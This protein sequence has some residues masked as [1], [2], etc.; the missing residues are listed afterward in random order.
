MSVRDEQEIAVAHELDDPAVVLTLAVV[1]AALGCVVLLDDDLKVV[2]ASSA[3][4]RAFDIDARGV[5]GRRYDELAEGAWGDP[6]LRRLLDLSL[7]DSA[8]P[9]NVTFDLQRRGRITRRL[10]ASA[11]RLICAEPDRVR[12]LLSVAD[13]TEARTSEPLH[14]L[15]EMD[16]L[17]LREA[18]HR[19]SNGLHIVAGLLWQSARL[20]E[21][22]SARGHLQAAYGRVTA[23]A[24]LERQLSAA[25]DEFVELRAYLTELCEHLAESAIDDSAR[26]SLRFFVDAVVV[27]VTTAASLGMIVTEL[28]VNALKHA[29]PG[30]RRGNVTIT[31]DAQGPDWTLTVADNGVG[32]PDP[33]PEAGLGTTIVSALATQLGA[34]VEVSDGFPGRIIAIS[35]RPPQPRRV[36]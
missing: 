26:V 18:R 14:E 24:A 7:L 16:G 12:L 32:K 5:L 22:E 6:Q 3:F 36:R 27:D 13:V 1:K 15:R 9:A 17:L 11:E 20:A 4:C 29:F 33:P 23:V 10:L 28:V 21:A 34:S 30:M 35:R 2:A 8:P 19:I 25:S 31:Y